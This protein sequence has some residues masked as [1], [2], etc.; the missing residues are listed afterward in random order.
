MTIRNVFLL[1]VALAGLQACATGLERMQ[2]HLAGQLRNSRGLSLHQARLPG[3]LVERRDP[4]ELRM[5]K[6]GHVLYIYHDYWSGKGFAAMP[7]DVFLEVKPKGQII[8]N[9]YATGS[10]CFSAY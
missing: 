8:A 2:A 10:G 5:L 4:T 9:A 7:C 6:N 3:G 1:V